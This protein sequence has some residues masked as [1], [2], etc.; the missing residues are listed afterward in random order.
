[1]FSTAQ[2]DFIN[3]QVAT[4]RNEGY[5][6]YIAYT[7]YVRDKGDLVDLYLIFSKEKITAKSL[8]SFNIPANS[9]QYSVISNN[10]S[11]SYDSN[12]S[13]RVAVRNMSEGVF[14][15][16]S[17]EHCY[18]N[19]YYSGMSTVLP[20]IT[21]GSEVQ[22]NATVTSLTII[23]ACCALLNMFMFFFKR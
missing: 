4:M 23:I 7:D 10:P 11:S 13:P 22:T 6:Y 2:I 9:V 12:R 19:A 14:T 17:F 20:D 21:K 18:T 8:Y 5:D 1:M 16:D 3:S 15:V